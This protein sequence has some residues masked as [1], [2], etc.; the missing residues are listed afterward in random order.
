MAR[1]EGEI[2]IGRF[3]DV[4]F[5]YVAD[6]SNESQHNLRMVW[7]AKITAGPRGREP[8]SARLWR[9]WGA[10]E[11]L[12]EC[13][14]YD[15]PALFALHH[16][17]AAASNRDVHDD[18]KSTALPVAREIVE[19]YVAA[20]FKAPWSIGLLNINL[21]NENLAEARRRIGRTMGAFGRDVTRVTRNLDSEVAGSAACMSGRS[22]P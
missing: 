12:I 19:T 7:A 17:D 14:G 3:V 5:D 9:P 21:N 13:T 2:V 6:V 16:D 18:S 20:P 22:Q 11:M 8:S 15:R 10:A 1:I 4:V